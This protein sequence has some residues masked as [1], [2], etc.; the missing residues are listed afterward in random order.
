M[1]QYRALLRA[2]APLNPIVAD[3]FFILWWEHMACGA[4]SPKRI[5][6]SYPL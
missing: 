3:I 6:I 4:V 2:E 5:P 1:F